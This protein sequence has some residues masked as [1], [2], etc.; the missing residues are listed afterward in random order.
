[1]APLSATQSPQLQLGEPSLTSI[2]RLSLIFVCC[3]FYSAIFF[4]VHIHPHCT[5]RS[6]SFLS[7][8]FATTFDDF[9]LLTSLICITPTLCQDP[10]ETSWKMSVPTESPTRLPRIRSYDP[11]SNPPSSPAAELTT[12][13]AA[14]TSSPACAGT[15]A[16]YASLICSFHLVCAPHLCSPGWLIPIHSNQL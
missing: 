15:H 7:W 11:R 8:T 1:M 12:P 16:I 10:R 9:S 14:G 13:G 4:F 2:P 5:S 3:Q 6:S